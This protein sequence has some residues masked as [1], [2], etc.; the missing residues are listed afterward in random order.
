M[1]VK[2]IKIS[3]KSRLVAFLLCYIFGICGA[4]RFYVGKTF[5]GI[6]FIFGLILPI[7]LFTV[8]QEGMFALVLGVI[9]WIALM[10]V[11]AIDAVMIIL[12]NFK[13]DK[14]KYIK[15]WIED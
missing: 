15:K 13:T 12:G 11:W 1:E 9:I 2:E 5:S 7:V 8:V 10:I 4:H 14:G 6:L 3:K